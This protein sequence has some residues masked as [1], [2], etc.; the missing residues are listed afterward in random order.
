[1]P[2]RN[3]PGIRRNAPYLSRRW[4]VRAMPAGLTRRMWRSPSVKDCPNPRL[5]A[6]AVHAPVRYPALQSRTTNQRV[7]RCSAAAN[8]KK[9]SAA[10]PGNGIPIPSST[11]PK[12][13][14]GY[15][16]A[17]NLSESSPNQ[18]STVCILL[19]AF[20]SSLVHCH[21]FIHTA[22]IGVKERYQWMLE[23]MLSH[24][25]VDGSER[26]CNG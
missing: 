2:G 18:V 22:M 5:S 4:A 1:M 7:K 23:A 26:V 12:N 10:S 20:H 15:P 21:P 3:R 9:V 16:S 19:A 14:A 11:S 6:Y 13:M 25:D 8:P 24:V 17:I